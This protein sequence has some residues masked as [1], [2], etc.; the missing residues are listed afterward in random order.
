M[1]SIGRFC[2]VIF[3]CDCGF[4]QYNA[5][6][7]DKVLA[8]N[9]E[10]ITAAETVK[11][12]GWKNCPTA[13]PIKA[14]GINTATMVKVEAVTANPISLVPLSAAFFGVSPASIK[15]EIFSTS[16]IASSTTMPITKARASSVR[17]SRLN[18]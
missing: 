4:S 6:T 13:P 17:V 2:F 3:A 15:R 14:T 18:P 12:K 8:I 5:K 9:R 7:G 1:F 16:T 11:P 10:K